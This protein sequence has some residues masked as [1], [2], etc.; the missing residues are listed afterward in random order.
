MKSRLENHV[1]KHYTNTKI[2]ILFPNQVFCCLFGCERK[3][4]QAWENFLYISLYLRKIK[5]KTWFWLLTHIKHSAHIKHTVHQHL[6]SS[7]LAYENHKGKGKI[8]REKVK[9]VLFP[10]IRILKA[11]TLWDSKDAGLRRSLISCAFEVLG[12][13]DQGAIPYRWAAA[14]TWIGLQTGNLLLFHRFLKTY[15]LQCLMYDL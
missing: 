9:P 14:L 10:K 1:D 12:S 4:M 6:F 11:Q 13:G 15:T 2:H 7:I 5:I 3:T 8:R